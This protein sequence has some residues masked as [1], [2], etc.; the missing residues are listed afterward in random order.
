MANSFNKEE[1]VAWESVLEEFQDTL[2]LSRN[3][4]KYQTDAQT[5]ER[6]NN[7]V[8]RPMP[9]ISTSYDGTDATANFNTATQLAVP[10]TFGF[11]KHATAILTATEMRDMLQE[12]RL[13]KAAVQKLSSDVNVAVMA[14]AA[15]QGTLFVKRSAAAAGFD[16]VA[17]CEAIFN[18]QGVAADS[19]Y[20]ALST[21]D[22]NGMASNLASRGTMAG[23]P[24]TAYEKA[25]VGTVASF[26]TY[27]LDYANRKTAAAG[28]GG[29]TIDTRD[30]GANYYTPVATRI[31]ATGEMSNVDNRYQTITV[32]S[33]TSVVAGDAF[34]VAALNAVHHITKNDTGQLKTFRVISVDSA[35]TMTISPPMTTNQVASDAGTQY[36]N[37]VI[38]TK[39]S[40]SAI[41]F[42]NTVTASVNPF[43][44]KDGI[45]ILPA[46]YV[47]PENSGVA[48]MR[49][50][51]DQ[52]IELVMTKWFDGNVFK[53]KYRWDI[54]FGVSM[55]QPEMCGLMMFGQT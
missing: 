16:D 52:D 48:V 10:A 28:G 32:S 51:T 37:C 24:T 27:K 23:K 4:S 47:V 12:G 11:A 53:T 18:E 21:R 41:V 13:G 25:Y 39:A 19:R 22:Y 46:R 26:E 45:E 36:Q 7:V 2:V 6:A 30:V 14:V 5:M 43:W 31:A 3:V 38:N 8:W 29:I 34:T 54:A 50:T 55:K 49:A 35:T 17:Q 44:H 15:N 42:L 40:N 33:T 9:Y 20:L 1:I